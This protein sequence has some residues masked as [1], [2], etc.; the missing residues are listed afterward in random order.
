MREGGGEEGGGEEGGG[1]REE[2]GGRGG[3]SESA[4][5]RRGRRERTSAEPQRH[6]IAGRADARSAN[7]AAVSGAFRWRRLRPA[8]TGLAM[9]GQTRIEDRVGRKRRRQ[10]RIV[11]VEVEV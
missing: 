8:G 1:R 4:R 6:G 7:G 10:T 2:G 11:S 5:Y 9:G 3:R